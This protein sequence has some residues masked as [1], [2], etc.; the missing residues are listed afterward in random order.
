[1]DLLAVPMD[2]WQWDPT[3][4]ARLSSF[5]SLTL[6]LTA[7]L[8]PL[9]KNMRATSFSCIHPLSLSRFHG[10]AVLGF[11][12]CVS[13]SSVLDLGKKTYTNLL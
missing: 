2:T 7:F 13:S 5:V 11:P 4:G 6:I 3:K 10:S 1:V 9:E 12:N 8:F